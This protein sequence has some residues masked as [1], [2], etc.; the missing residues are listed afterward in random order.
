MVVKSECCGWDTWGDLAG[1]GSES[2]H[3]SVPQQVTANP[4]PHPA[5]PNRLGKQPVPHTREPDED[6]YIGA[7]RWREHSNG[8]LLRKTLTPAGSARRHPRLPRIRHND[9]QPPPLHQTRPGT[10]LHTGRDRGTARTAAG[11]E[12]DCPNSQTTRA[13]QDNR[14]RKPDSRPRTHPRCPQPPRR[15]MPWQPRPDR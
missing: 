15:Q 4:D 5:A 2:D 6:R 7:R 8:P 12:H 10:R 3:L 9:G 13:S 1:F 11:P 14:G